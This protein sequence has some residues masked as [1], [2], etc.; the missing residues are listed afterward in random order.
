[1]VC[2]LVVQPP[3]LRIVKTEK[4]IL[5]IGKISRLRL[6]SHLPAPKLL[7][8][9]E[10]SN[11]ELASAQPGRADLWRTSPSYGPMKPA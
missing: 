9:L 3:R 2:A 4:N 11:L 5:R 10:L 8:N 6:R 1:M 7:L